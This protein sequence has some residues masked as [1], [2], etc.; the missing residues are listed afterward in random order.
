MHDSS[1]VHSQIGLVDRLMASSVVGRLAMIGIRTPS[2]QCRPL[3]TPFVLMESEVE[4][5]ERPLRA[6]LQLQIGPFVPVSKGYLS[7]FWNRDKA[8]GTK[9]LEAFVPGG[10]TGTKCPSR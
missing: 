5:S 9:A 8:A 4:G 2:A 7:R 6:L 1:E 10:R 3:K